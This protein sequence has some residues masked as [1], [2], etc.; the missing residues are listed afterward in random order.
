M[1]EAIPL[2]PAFSH[3]LTTALYIEGVKCHFSTAQLLAEEGST[4]VL[5]FTV[6]ATPEMRRIANRARVHFIAT[7]PAPPYAV[8]VMGEYELAERGFDKSTDARS[9]VFTATHV[10]GHLDQYPLTTLNHTTSAKAL[11]GSM[12]LTESLLSSSTGSVLEYFEP[13]RL[14]DALVEFNK[15]VTTDTAYAAAKVAAPAKRKLDASN[16]TVSDVVL[17]AFLLY[18]KVFQASRISDT[19]T[20]AAMD[21]HQLAARFQYP[22][23]DLIDWPELYQTLMTNSLAFGPAQVGGRLTFMDLIRT[24]CQFFLYQV[25]VVP[26]AESVTKQIQIKPMT[27]F[28]AI[29]KCNV[30]Y[31]CMIGNVSFK[32]NFAYKPTRMQTQ[33]IPPGVSPNTD[34]SAVER[35]LTFF[36][37]AELQYLWQRILDANVL[38]HVA[39]KVTADAIA[40]PIIKPA[41]GLPFLTREENERGIV[42]I[43]YNLPPT[44]NSVILSQ[45]LLH[46]EELNASAQEKLPGVADAPARNAAVSK[47]LVSTTPTD[48]VTKYRAFLCIALGDANG[49][50]PALHPEYKKTPYFAKGKLTQVQHL[51]AGDTYA[52]PD[53][54]TLMPY[55]IVMSQ[56][57]QGLGEELK[58]SGANYIIAE[59]GTVVKLRGRKHHTFAEPQAIPYGLTLRGTSRGDMVQ[60]NSM[61]PPLSVAYAAWG[62]T[63]FTSTC[64]NLVMA[65]Y[66]VA[67]GGNPVGFIVQGT[68]PNGTANS[69]LFKYAVAP[70]P[71]TVPA[72]P[73]NATPGTGSIDRTPGFVDRLI[74]GVTMV[75]L[76]AKDSAGKAVKLPKGSRYP[77]LAVDN[78]AINPAESMLLLRLTGNDLSLPVTDKNGQAISY[79]VTISNKTTH[80]Q[81]KPW[82]FCENPDVAKTVNPSNLNGP[83]GDIA[84]GKAGS[85]NRGLNRSQ[86]ATGSGNE[87]NLVIALATTT[88]KLSKAQQDAAAFLV[89]IVQ[90]LSVEK[91]G[92]TTQPNLSPARCP[93]VP[94]VAEAS[95]YYA[96]TGLDPL[97]PPITKNDMAAI[98][99]QVNKLRGMLF[100]N[101]NTWDKKLIGQTATPF[102]AV[103][104]AGAST[105]DETLP[106]PLETSSSAPPPVADSGL[107]AAAATA[108]IPTGAEAKVLEVNLTDIS[109]VSKGYL[110]GYLNYQFYSSRIATQNMTLPM[111]FNPYMTIGYPALVLDNTVG[112]YDLV[113][114]L[115]A[116]THTFTP[117]S[118]SSTAVITH[119]RR[120]LTEDPRELEVMAK[121]DELNK[122]DPDKAKGTEASTHLFAAQREAMIPFSKTLLEQYVFIAPIN[123]GSEVSKPMLSTK[124]APSTTVITKGPVIGPM[125]TP[126]KIL[127][128]T[129]RQ[130]ANDPALY[131]TYLKGLGDSAKSNP[132]MLPSTFLPIQLHDLDTKL[133]PLFVYDG[134][135]G[136]GKVSL[137]TAKNELKGIT[138]D[139]RDFSRYAVY[140]GYNQG[141]NN[142]L[143]AGGK[144][145]APANFIFADTIPDDRRI[146]VIDAYAYIQRGI[147]RVGQNN[148]AYAHASLVDY[149]TTE[150]LLKYL[151]PVTESASLNSFQQYTGVTTDKEAPDA[152]L[153]PGLQGIPDSIVVY[154]VPPTF[155]KGK[156]TAAGQVLI[157]NSLIR[158]Q[159]YAHNEHIE[160]YE[161]LSNVDA[162]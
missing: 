55:G 78:T 19:Y 5:Y 38:G 86:I 116:V 122:S 49:I 156:Q 150:D 3:A 91:P 15:T 62:I 132:A 148:L 69:L 32:E 84:K 135:F 83:L 56:H 154:K 126:G 14:K 124:R 50:D 51:D 87:Q 153:V 146:S 18:R 71:F 74:P 139:M 117:T 92:T 29:P 9:L 137:D 94:K 57:Q 10:T 103:V 93:R 54:I 144:E 70:H 30:F 73:T 44:L 149:E 77:L 12:D 28:N 131:F 65:G 130:I 20:N 123:E 27:Y 129:N 79:D 159:V 7:E 107:P 104:T 138:E 147:Q 24:I 48:R 109:N 4:P 59:D 125:T 40:L 41:D 105:F 23:P 39:T 82:I 2:N 53:R 120:S 127:P 140:L 119:L 76:T 63:K 60:L 102:N 67:T 162:N 113:G 110:R 106:Y 90:E 31:P 108:A 99:G 111:P 72:L 45:T 143:A 121:Q 68:A 64:T 37:P 142:Q 16:L 100:D 112:G 161:V 145:G 75:Y 95:S 118:G 80:E 21:I 8:V 47:L 157:F 26:N 158:D 136:L 42:P 98:T 58:L 46:P 115:H 43:Q 13:V 34:L 152:T 96:G 36:A 85:A 66:S 17:G 101:F 35:N 155:V 114:Y 25:T 151:D 133:P 88:G 81:F 97:T 89:A 52:V 1:P 61:T 6:P 22:D 33:F 128:Y 134:G 160:Q 11:G 141:T